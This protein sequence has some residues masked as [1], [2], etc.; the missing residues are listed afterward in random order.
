MCT[1]MEEVMCLLYNPEEYLKKNI[2]VTDKMY[3][4]MSCPN[5]PAVLHSKESLMEYTNKEKYYFFTII[6]NP[7]DRFLSGFLDKCVR[8]RIQN[9]TRY[10]QCYGCGY[11]IECF[12]NIIYKRAR[13]FHDTGI[14]IPRTM[15]DYHFMPQAWKC[16]L[17][18]EISKYKI[19]DYSNKS[20]LYDDLNT[21]FTHVGVPKYLRDKIQK[22]LTSNYTEHH[23]FDLPYRKIFETYLR[24]EKVLMKKLINL[25]YTDFILFNYSIPDLDIDD[26]KLII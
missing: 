20:K 16:H 10:N 1:V 4:F 6:R 13:Q 11:D 15:E 14:L 17:N 25:Y 21:F 18:D 5:P 22:D 3:D 24:S 12:I 19:F 7:I 8:E 9:K 2:S 26:N 23:T